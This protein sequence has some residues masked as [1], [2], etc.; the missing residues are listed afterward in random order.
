MNAQ[1]DFY[2]GGGL[3]VCFLGMAETTAN[4]N[5]NVSRLEEK[6]LTGPGGFIDITQSTRKV[7][8]M[9]S[10]T[11]KGA[12]LE[13]VPDPANPRHRGALRIAAEG[14][15]R[16]FVARTRE[17]TFSGDEAVRRGQKVLY[18]TER[19]VF[20]R[21]AAHPV[22]EL[23]EIA[24]GIDL[25]RDVLSHMD[26]APVVSPELKTMDPR[27]FGLEPMG[28][29][30]DF[31]GRTVQDR[32]IYHEADHALYVDLTG[33]TLATVADVDQVVGGIEGVMKPLVAKGGPLNVV[34]NYDNFDLRVEVEKL[35]QDRVK[36][37]QAKYYKTVRRYTGSAF[38]R[39]RLSKNLSMLSW[40]AD[41][42]FREFDTNGDGVVSP[43]ELREGVRKHYSLS[44]TERDVARF[45]KGQQKG[46]DR[47]TFL[48]TLNALL[49]EGG[50]RGGGLG[51]P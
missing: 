37:L 14:A 51:C 15:V 36:E 17:V 32:C 33:I 3:D 18:V 8:F 46:I 20:Q 9:G 7:V 44:L 43:A 34:V 10:F 12:K 6:R 47:E 11:A 4:G 38:R 30:E 2:N 31:F 40:G 21:T 50:G 19:A 1:F 48:A 25:H 22:I 41:D 35:Y 13:F 39:Q 5:V 26:F 27:I 23:I 49:C 24:P 16:K 28:L 45:F 42:M 29:R